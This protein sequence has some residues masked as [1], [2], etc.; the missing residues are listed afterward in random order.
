MSFEPG[1]GDDEFRS[2]EGP[3]GSGSSPDEDPADFS[4]NLPPAKSPEGTGHFYLDGSGKVVTDDRCG[5][6]R[7]GHSQQRRPGYINPYWDTSIQEVVENLE[8]L[9]GFETSSPGDSELGLSGP[10]S[11]S[12]T[13]ANYCYTAAVVGG[14]NELILEEEPELHLMLNDEV[15]SID[16]SRIP[17]NAEEID[18]AVAEAALNSIDLLHRY[19]FAPFRAVSLEDSTTRHAYGNFEAPFVQSREVVRN[20][21]ERRINTFDLRAEYIGTVRALLN[22]ARTYEGLLVGTGPLSE[23]MST[24]VRDLAETFQVPIA[25]EISDEVPLNVNVSSRFRR[26]VPYEMITNACKCVRNSVESSENEEAPVKVVLHRVRDKI[27]LMVMNKGNP[28][29]LDELIEGNFNAS[30]H[31]G[32][33]PLDSSD[34]QPNSGFGMVPM[35]QEVLRSGGEVNIEAVRG[36]ERQRIHVMGEMLNDHEDLFV[37]IREVIDGRN[38]IYSDYRDKYNTFV[39]VVF[40]APLSGT[41]GLLGSR[42]VGQS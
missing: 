29:D 12:V 31:P 34:V 33:S 26:A 35:L 32:T 18:E 20:L 14:S 23:S 3:F 6:G 36:E 41:T 22:L 38:D 27:R 40:D 2:G 30:N 5:V 15:V 19:I 17:S 13:D 21:I 16:L 37:F 4:S 10:Y 9:V 39:E 25:I 7:S 42:S 28:I 1:E 8:D 24:I 11:Y